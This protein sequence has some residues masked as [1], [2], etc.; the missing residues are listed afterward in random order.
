MKR[1]LILFLLFGLNSCLLL[2]N[3]ALDQEEVQSDANQALALAGLSSA[4]PDL[5]AP[6]VTSFDGMGEQGS[7]TVNVYV[8][9]N[10]AETAYAAYGSESQVMTPQNSTLIGIFPLLGSPGD[11]RVVINASGS[12]P[13]SIAIAARSGFCEGP[14]ELL[15]L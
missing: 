9:P 2:W 6:T 15:P 8:V 4:C 10:S 5:L 13:P 1:I 7:Y 3:E 12:Q 11:Q 14:W